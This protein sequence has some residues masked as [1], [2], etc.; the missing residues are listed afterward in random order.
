MLLRLAR[1][2]L[3][4]LGAAL[5]LGHGAVEAKYDE[6]MAKDVYLFARAAFQLGV[7]CVF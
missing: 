7:F 5:A 6:Q 3:L 1:V 4:L 2:T